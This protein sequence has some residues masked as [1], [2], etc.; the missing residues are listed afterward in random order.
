ML[1]AVDPERDERRG[2]GH[3]ERS[4]FDI[5]EVVRLRGT[6]GMDWAPVTSD[7]V[8]FVTTYWWFGEPAS[9]GP[10]SDTTR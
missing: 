8:D 1:N 5:D 3:S 2:D 7:T 6:T 4:S 10:R 9:D